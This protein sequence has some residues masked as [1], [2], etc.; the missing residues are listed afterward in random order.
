MDGKLI[1]VDGLPGS[2][3]S[4]T[5]QFICDQLQRRGL[6]ARWYYEEETP[7][8]VAAIRGLGGPEGFQEYSRAVRRRWRAFARR[9]ARGR[10]I[11]IIESYLFQDAILPLLMTD[12][13]PRLI[14]AHLEAVARIC[15]PLDPVLV[16]LHQPDYAPAMRRIC[17]H[18]GPRIEKAYIS[19]NERSR[20][21]QRHG[22]TGFDG[23]VRFWVDLRSIAE[24]VFR[25]LD[26]RKLA[27]D[28][29]AQ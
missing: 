16:Y 8:P 20:Y 22:L 14:V 24:R 21:G 17:E 19:R 25:E 6:Q 27:I 3:K 28:N 12:V 7:H 11:A 13:D 9:T 5:A 23:L 18:R 15:Q 29:T 2:G 4:S 26:W 1:L 10:E